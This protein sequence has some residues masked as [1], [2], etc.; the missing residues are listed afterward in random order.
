MGVIMIKY[1]II[2]FFFFDNVFSSDI[3]FF[4]SNYPGLDK[5]NIVT[6]NEDYIKIKLKNQK[7][8]IVSN[9]NT[10]DNRE[11]IY[12]YSGYIDALNSHLINITLWEG[13]SYFLVNA[14]NGESAVIWS[15]PIVSPDKKRFACF[16]MDLLPHFNPNGIQIW[17]IVNNHFI[18][19][20]SYETYE[21]GPSGLKWINNNKL[22]FIENISTNYLADTYLLS[23][24]YLSYTTNWTIE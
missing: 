24:A 19:E 9:S 2:L 6:I 15:P 11:C 20:W 22:K 17:K 3:N 16:S 4:I 7:Y 13:S 14:V 23:N 1:L 21:W 12:T 5:R 18:Q 10:D 8:F